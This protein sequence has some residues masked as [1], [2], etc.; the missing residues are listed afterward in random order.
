M[1]FEPANKRHITMVAPCLRTCNP[2]LPAPALLAAGTTPESPFVHAAQQQQQQSAAASSAAAAAAAAAAAGPSRLMKA[3][4]VPGVVCV[5]VGVC[6]G[7]GVGGWMV[8][9][10]GLRVAETD[11][12]LSCVGCTSCCVHCFAA[13]PV[14]SMAPERSRPHVA[15]ADSH[16][17]F[18]LIHHTCCIRVLQVELLEEFYECLCGL[19]EKTRLSDPLSL[20]LVHKVGVERERKGS[21]KGQQQVLKAP[22]ARLYDLSAVGSQQLGVLLLSQQ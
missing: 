6:V 3:A 18:M 20:T 11:M 19:V 12:T 17:A 22:C 8:T 9:G 14:S 2:T 4:E 13:S 7:V 21:G 10:R 5:W 16:M 15:A 1:T